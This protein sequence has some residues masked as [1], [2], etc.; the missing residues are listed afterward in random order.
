MLLSS[1][2]FHTL[3]EHL[4]HL[5]N[6]FIAAYETKKN[7]QYSLNCIVIFASHCTQ[8]SNLLYEMHISHFVPPIWKELIWLWT[9]YDKRIFKAHYEGLEYVSYIFS[10]RNIV[11]VNTWRKFM[12]FVSWQ[13]K[14][15]RIFFE[16]KSFHFFCWK[17]FFPDI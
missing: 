17:M 6:H 9:A 2:Y 12:K 16:H 8:Y 1:Q 7:K 14:R 3:L 15:D 11:H 4:Q 13:H 10:Q 5:I